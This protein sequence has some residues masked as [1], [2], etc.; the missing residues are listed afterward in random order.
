[1]PNELGLKLAKLISG[2]FVIGNVIKHSI[3]TNVFKINISFD[4][5]T[6]SPN[7]NMVPYMHPL[8]LDV[9]LVISLDKCITI[10]DPS[11]Q[12]SGLYVQHITEHIKKTQ[13]QENVETKEVPTEE[14]KPKKKGKT[15]GDQSSEN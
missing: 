5:N 15:N 10:T 1:M 7:I 2:E 9:G 12:I 6:G 4:Q 13:E 11:E 3:L 14:P 8:N